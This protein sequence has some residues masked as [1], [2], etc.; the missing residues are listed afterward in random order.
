MK[1]MTIHESKKRPLQVKFLA[2]SLS[3][4]QLETREILVT[5]NP[6]P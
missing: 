3:I 2:Q 6:K 4:H 1:E 5:L